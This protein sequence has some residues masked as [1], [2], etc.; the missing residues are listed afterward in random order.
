MEAMHSLYSRSNFEM[1]EF[2]P[3]VA[4]IYQVDHLVL[5]RKLYEWTAV[6]ATDIDETRYQILKKLSEVLLSEWLKPEFATNNRHS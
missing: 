6:D 2:E 5:L 4:L 3:L 1:E